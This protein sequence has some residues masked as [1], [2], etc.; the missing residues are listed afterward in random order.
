MGQGYT[1][2]TPEE[3]ESIKS[4]TNCIIYCIYNLIIVVHI[5]IS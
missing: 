4:M 5:F 3:I 1:H 2:M